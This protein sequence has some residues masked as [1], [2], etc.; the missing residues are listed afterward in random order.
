MR[1]FN[2]V[3]ILLV[4]F[5]IGVGVGSGSAQEPGPV[6]T[7]T[8][9]VPPE[10]PVFLEKYEPQ[11][12]D[13][14]LA[15]GLILETIDSK[16]ALIMPKAIAWQEKYKEQTGSYWQGLFSH[17]SIPALSNNYPDGWFNKPTDVGKRW[18]DVGIINFETMPYRLKVDVYNGPS[19]PGW[20]ACI[21]AYDGSRY[22]ERCTGYGGEFR[23]SEW[24][25][26]I[27]E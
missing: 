11:A 7:P 17:S 27:N 24:A 4:L 22:M 19:G 26:V 13:F 25:P 16:L 23:D 14:S 21:Q 2:L 10:E 9:V 18:A 8:P 5:C 12:I 20:V 6:G 3:L 15:N 1:R